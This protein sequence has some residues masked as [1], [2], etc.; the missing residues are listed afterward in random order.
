MKSRR[1]SLG[2][3]RVGIVLSHP[4]HV[5]LGTDSRL[6]NQVLP[7]ANNG[8]DLTL[9]SPFARFKP[10]GFPTLKCMSLNKHPTIYEDAYRFTRFALNQ[11]AIARSLLR[12]SH[13]L[14]FSANAFARKLE[15]LI[16]KEHFDVLLAVHQLA[17]AACSK[18][19]KHRVPVV[20]DIHGIWAEE[21]QFSGTLAKGSVQSKVCEQFE[22]ESL[23]HNE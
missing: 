12:T 2:R 4:F 8:A 11:P 23:V 18:L 10:E 16:S 1:T 21:L 14:D 22:R 5:G 17:A 19:K 7:M 6:Q 15:G 3:L 20:S 13:Y 9:I